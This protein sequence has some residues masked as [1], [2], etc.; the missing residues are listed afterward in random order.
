[1]LYISQTT[2]DVLDLVDMYL[3]GLHCISQ[4]RHAR[5]YCCEEIRYISQTTT[6]ALDLVV[7]YLCGKALHFLDN[8]CTRSCC[9]VPIQQC[10]I[11][12]R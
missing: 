2:I 8:R 3:C 5:S 12:L 4:T 9:Y 11:F 7:M 6:D 10:A 1:M